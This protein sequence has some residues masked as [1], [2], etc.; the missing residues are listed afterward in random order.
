MYIVWAFSKMDVRNKFKGFGKGS[1]SP[2]KLLL[3]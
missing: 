3:M 2:V 1:I